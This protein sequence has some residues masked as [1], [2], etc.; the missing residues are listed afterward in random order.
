M[1]IND[2]IGALDHIARDMRSGSSFTAALVE[3]LGAHPTEVPEKGQALAQGYSTREALNSGP[4]AGGA[5]AATDELVLQ[6]LRACHRGGGPAVVALERAAA[7]LRERR[8]WRAER[9]AQSAQARLSARILTILPRAVGLWA[10]VTSPRV[11]AAYVSNPVP[12]VAAAAGVALDLCGLW[13]MRRIVAR[14]VP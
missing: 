4:I 3:G 2:A 6:A 9:V 5:Q 13:W 8:A 7:V 11:R 1:S 12:L 10:V 14:G